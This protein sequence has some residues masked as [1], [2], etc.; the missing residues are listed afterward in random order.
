MVK[1]AQRAMTQLVFLVMQATIVYV[2]QVQII[3]GMELIVVNELNF[4]KF[5]NF[6]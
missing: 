4:G 3:F 5:F 2:I 1:F 6:C